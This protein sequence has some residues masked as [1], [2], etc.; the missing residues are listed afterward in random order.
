[1]STYNDADRIPANVIDHFYRS[2][3][4]FPGHAIGIRA[5]APEVLAHARVIAFSGSGD[6]PGFFP[7]RW[8][9]AAA[10]S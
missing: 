9:T 5:S 4:A 8:T 6:R 3:L 2:F 7:A 1:M 10:R